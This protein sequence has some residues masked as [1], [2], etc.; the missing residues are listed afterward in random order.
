[1]KPKDAAAS[2]EQLKK[3]L[4]GGELKRFYLLFGSERYLRNFYEKKLLKAMGG[5]RDDMNTNIFD[6]NPVQASSIIDA[7]QTMPFFADRRVVVVRYSGFFKKNADELADFLS[8]APDTTSFIFVE[9]EADAR[10]KLYKQISKLGRCVEFTTQSDRY[11]LQNIGAF[12]KKQNQRIGQDDA[13]YFLGVIGT[14]MGKL[15]SELEK[16]SA[17]AM[18]RDVITREDIDTICSRNIEDRIFEMIDAVMRRDIHTVMDRYEDLLALKLAPVRIVV[19]L[20]KQFLWMLQLKSMSEDAGMHL[21]DIINTIA[22]R[23]EVD[24]ETGEV[25]RSRG[26]IGEFQVKKYLQQASHMSSA[27]LQRAVSLCET[28]DEDFKTGRMNDKMA[29]ET[30]LVKLCNGK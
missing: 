30:L 26:E 18:D 4:S 21:T 1:M 16:L 11:L 27:E 12:L 8:Q 5:S 13:E 23:Q 25:K 28:A 20:E 29:T 7:A 3:D 22:F 14:D 17:Y 2:L 10:L 6:M 24:E 19:M 15:M 9:D